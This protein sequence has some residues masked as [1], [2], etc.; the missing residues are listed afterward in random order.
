[1]SKKR[2]ITKKNAKRELW[3][4]YGFESKD[5]FLKK[6]PNAERKKSKRVNRQKLGEKNSKIG[7]N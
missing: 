2:A 4:E 5:E 1:M 3:Q 7:F 6:Y